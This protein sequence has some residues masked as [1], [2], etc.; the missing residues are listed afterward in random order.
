MKRSSLVLWSACAL[1]IALPAFATDYTAA[2]ARI[3]EAGAALATNEAGLE[4]PERFQAFIDLYLEYTLLEHPEMATYMGV[5]GDHGRWTDNSPAAQE[6]RD[7]TLYEALDLLRSIDRSRLDAADQLNYDLLMESFKTDIEGQRFKGDYL[8]VNQMGGTHSSVARM[9]SMI[10][11]GS[12]E[13]NST[14][15]ENFA[16][17]AS[18]DRR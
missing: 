2:R 5:D 6:R 3:M 11:W 15:P 12:I 18:M 17:C 7:Q 16:I 14:L 13:D 10:T 8:Q 4:E 9:L 1:V